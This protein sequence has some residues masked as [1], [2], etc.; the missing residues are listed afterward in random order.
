MWWREEN[1][2]FKSLSVSWKIFLIVQK[3]CLWV[4][5]ACGLLGGRFLRDTAEHQRLL[6]VDSP[7]RYC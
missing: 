2:F 5:V 7:R 4:F 1:G 3:S 6:E